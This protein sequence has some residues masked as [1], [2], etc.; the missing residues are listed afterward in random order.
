M[1]INEKL[2]LPHAMGL[3]HPQLERAFNGLTCFSEELPGQDEIHVR[4]TR[5]SGGNMHKLVRLG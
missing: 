4:A 2:E 3:Q 1:L 5:G